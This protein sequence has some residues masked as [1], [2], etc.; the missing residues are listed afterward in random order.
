MPWPVGETARA[1][2]RNRPHFPGF[3]LDF[4]KLRDT[5]SDAGSA[6][7]VEIRNAGPPPPRRTPGAADATEGKGMPP[8]EAMQA[9]VERRMGR[10][11]SFSEVEDLIDECELRADEKAALWLLAWTYLDRRAQRREARALL[12]ALAARAQEMSVNRR[13]LKAV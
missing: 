5:V 10:G 11:E 9:E 13:L 1:C 7:T 2:A 3:L 6:A 12:G 4:A 8:I